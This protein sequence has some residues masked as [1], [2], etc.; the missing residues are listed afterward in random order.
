MCWF[1]LGSRDGLYLLSGSQRCLPREVLT[2]ADGL[3]EL[4]GLN[5]FKLNPPTQVVQPLAAKHRHKYK[6]S[7]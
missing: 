7:A 5:S 2:A 6:T 4:S 3:G 1:N